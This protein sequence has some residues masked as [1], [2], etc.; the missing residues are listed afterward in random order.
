M[1]SAF[2]SPEGE[3]PVSVTA[4]DLLARN[5]QPSPAVDRLLEAGLCTTPVRG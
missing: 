3:R 5:G 1:T 4:D 2:S